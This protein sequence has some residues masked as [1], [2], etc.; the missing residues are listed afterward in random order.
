MRPE[1]NKADFAKSVNA[2]WNARDPQHEQILAW[3]PCETLQVR[4]DALARKCGTAKP[5]TLPPHL[6][7]LQTLFK[8]ELGNGIIGHA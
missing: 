2:A 7:M 1:R 3:D 5:P 4:K 8:H 6:Q